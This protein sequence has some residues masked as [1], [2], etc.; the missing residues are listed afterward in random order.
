MTSWLRQF[1]IHVSDID[2]TIK[3]YETLGLECTSRTKITDDIDEAVIENPGKGGWIQLAKNRTIK[4]PIDMGSSM[5]KLYVYTDNC[6][7]A[8]DRAMAAGYESH[9]APKKA[10]RWPTTIAFIKDPDGYLVELC[11]RDEIPTARNAGGSPRDQSLGKQGAQL[12]SWFRQFCFFVSDIE[13]T[14]KFYETVGLECTSRTKIT[15]DI[16]EAVVENPER[17]AW[18]QL[19]SNKANTGPIDM[20][21]AVWKLYLYTDD[22]QAVYDRAMAA[23][24]ESHTVPRRLERWPTTVGFIKDPDGY[25]IELLQRDERPTG[26]TAGGS[27]RDQSL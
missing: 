26:R 18:I 27:P 3:F 16:D 15:D 5:W 7:A 4:G 1:C 12:T 11:Q 8:Y 21:S 25:L 2:A 24:Y 17:G 14:I 6:Q 23:G 13:K 9:T 10:D 19:A 22:C 20:G